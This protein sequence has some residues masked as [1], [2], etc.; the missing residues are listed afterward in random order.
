MGES[1]LR[2]RGNPFQRLRSVKNLKTSSF[3]FRFFRRSVVFSQERTN[4]RKNDEKDP[5]F[6]FFSAFFFHE[7]TAKKKKEGIRRCI[8]P[9][10]RKG[11]GSKFP[12]RDA[13]I[14]SRRLERTPRS[15]RKP[16]EEFSFLFDDRATPKRRRV[17]F[18]VLAAWTTKKKGEIF[19]FSFSRERTKSTSPKKKDVAHATVLRFCAARSFSFF[20]AREREKDGARAK[21]TERR[22]REIPKRNFGSLRTKDSTAPESG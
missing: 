11:I 21:R 9:F 19:F 14:R 4:R 10:Y 5:F 12:N 6:F 22:A 17:D 8:S 2:D 7:K 20:L 15:R 13:R 18:F 3:S 16:R 1:V